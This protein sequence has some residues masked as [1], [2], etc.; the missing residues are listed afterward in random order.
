MK[1][2]KQVSE[3]NNFMTLEKSNSDLIYVKASTLH[4]FYKQLFESCGFAATNAQIAADGIYYSDLRGFD[5]HGCVNLLNIY[6]PLI[7]KSKIAVSSFPQIIS[8]NKACIVVDADNTLGYIAGHFAMEEAITCAKNY[9]IGCAVVRNSSHAGSF[10]FYTKQAVDAKMIGI[11]LTNLGKQGLLAPPG[12]IMP[13]IGTNVI[14]V[15]APTYSM[16]YFS[17][18]MSTAIVSAGRIRQYA[19]KGKQVP[20]GWLIDKA[21][22][23][24]TD[25]LA[26]IKGAAKLAFIGGGQGEGGYKGYGLALLVD[27]LCGI[28]SG[29]NVGPNLQQLKNDGTVPINQAISHFF[30]AINPEA[31]ITLDEF[32]NRLDEMLDVICK[33]TPSNNQQSVIYPGLQEYKTAKERASNGIPLMSE[34][35]AAITKVAERYK[36]LKPEIYNLDQIQESVQ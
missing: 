4:V 8:K 26:F 20:L 2:F 16:P 3:E 17:L 7:E 9:G 12:G 15:A 23:F 28:L 33:S 35:F 29:G 21:G 5:T 27:I 24:T 30:L 34:T 13:L 6:L 18:D 31:F 36:I 22:N 10:G 32:C 1:L 11:A 19:K 14:A 25:P